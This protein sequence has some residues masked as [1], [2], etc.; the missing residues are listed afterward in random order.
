MCST[1][2]RAT[3]ARSRS[4]LSNR[5]SDCAL[6]RRAEGSFVFIPRGVLHTFW[7]ESDAP[8]RQLTVF[9]PAGIEDYFDAVSQVI[10]AGGDDS[11]EAAIALMEQHDMV[12]AANTREAYGALQ[13][14]RSTS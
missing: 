14:R 1:S 13:P 6:P 3:A 12:V 10:A 9:T 8:A 2:T 7:N 5:S 4:S 11:L